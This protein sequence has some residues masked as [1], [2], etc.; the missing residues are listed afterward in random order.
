MLS[1]VVLAI[2]LFLVVRAFLFRV[3]HVD[4]NSMAP[5]LEHGDLVIL[6]RLVYVLGSPQV[7]DIVAF[8]YADNPSDFFIKRV[9]AVPG[10]IVDLRDGVFY[11]NDLPIEDEFSYETIISLG[12]VTFPT[13]PIADGYIFVLG[14]NRNNSRDSRFADVGINDDGMVRKRDVVGRGNLRIWPLGRWGRVN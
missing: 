11:V 2:L 1:M 7:G 14:D 10:D 6:N 12:N 3:A 9:I 5:T 8:P 4:G 13:P